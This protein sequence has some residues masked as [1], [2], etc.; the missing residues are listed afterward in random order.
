MALTMMKL[1]IVELLLNY[2]WDEMTRPEDFAFGMNYIPNMSA[3]VKLR[4]NV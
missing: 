1:M 4:K 3:Q 2:E